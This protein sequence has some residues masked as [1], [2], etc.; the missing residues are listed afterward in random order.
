MFH[1]H[2][3]RIKKYNARYPRKRDMDDDLIDLLLRFERLVQAFVSLNRPKTSTTLCPV[4]AHSSWQQPPK[5]FLFETFGWM[6]NNLNICFP[7][8]KASVYIR[9][10][11]MSMM[12]KLII[13]RIMMG[14]L[15]LLNKQTVGDQSKQQ[16]YL[17]ENDNILNPPLINNKIIISITTKHFH[18]LL[19]LLYIHSL[20]L[21]RT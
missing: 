18:L 11:M 12:I 1:I 15:I 14:I 8:P 20:I 4:P 7:V 6:L 17:F 5:P 2:T 13:P 19:V 3:L 9:I 10:L 16:R 21:S